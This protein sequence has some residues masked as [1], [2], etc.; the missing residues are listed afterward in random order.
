MGGLIGFSVMLASVVFAGAHAQST[1]DLRKSLMAKLDAGYNEHPVGV[2]VA[3]TGNVVELIVSPDGTWT[4]VVTKPNGIACI[5]AVGEDWQ[6]V[7][8]PTL[9]KA[10]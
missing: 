6:A 10:S 4:I 7:E 8:P 5:A 1:C 9:D 2:G 3:S